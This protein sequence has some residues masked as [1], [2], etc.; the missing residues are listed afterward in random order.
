MQD[1]HVLIFASESVHYNTIYCVVSGKFHI[2]L[3]ESESKT[4]NILV[5]FE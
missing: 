3:G 5:L 1:N 4:V 2:Y